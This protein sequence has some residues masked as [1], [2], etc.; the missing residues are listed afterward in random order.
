M[1]PGKEGAGTR[2]VEEPS[3]ELGRAQ[4]Q[5]RAPPAHISFP[6]NTFYSHLNNRSASP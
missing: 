1:E 2:G 6:F 5:R 4:E 3:P